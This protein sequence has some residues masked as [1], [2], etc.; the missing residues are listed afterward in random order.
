MDE[1]ACEFVIAFV[2]RQPRHLPVAT[3]DPS[4]DQRRFTEAGRGGDEGQLAV[5]TIVQPVHQRGPGY[6]FRR[7]WWDEQLGA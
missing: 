3:G 7:R 6:R 5:Q 4:A 2:Q 1:K